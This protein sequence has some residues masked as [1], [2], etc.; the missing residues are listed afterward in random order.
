MAVMG[1][2]GGVDSHHQWDLRPL[3]SRLQCLS[4]NPA[5]AFAHRQSRVGGPHDLTPRG[6]DGEHNHEKSL[7]WK[8]QRQ[9]FLQ[10][11]PWDTW[12]TV[13]PNIGWRCNIG[14]ELDGSLELNKVPKKVDHADMEARQVLDLVLQVKSQRT[15]AWQI[16]GASGLVIHVRTHGTES[17]LTLCSKINCRGNYSIW[18]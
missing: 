18:N 17:L 15:R 12:R 11:G 14:T 1:K 2:G 10:K 13:S 8:D 7:W 3:S 4:S 6:A 5:R 9:A 16:S